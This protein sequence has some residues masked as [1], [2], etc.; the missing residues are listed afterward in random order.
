VV[1]VLKAVACK[2]NTTKYQPQQK[3][4][5]TTNWEQDDRCGNSTTQSQAPDDILMSET[6]WAHKKWNKI[7][8]GIKLVLHSSTNPLSLPGIR[9][10]ISRSLSHYT[11]WASAVPCSIQTANNFVHPSNHHTS[12]KPIQH[13][14]C[15]YGR[16]D[17][18]YMSKQKVAFLYIF[19]AE[20]PKYQPPEPRAGRTAAKFETH[21]NFLIMNIDFAAAATTNSQR[22][23]LQHLQSIHIFDITALWDA[24]I[25]FNNIYSS[26]HLAVCVCTQLCVHNTLQPQVYRLIFK[27]TIPTAQWRHW[28]SIT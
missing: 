9:N 21:S 1:F 4:Q 20:F 14:S 10:K 26:A 7:A 2:T 17:W 28:L 5:H 3:L 25:N 12:R 15:C 13:C 18:Q 19:A 22:L 27:T 16:T 11:Y 8:S 6:C 23:C 24:N